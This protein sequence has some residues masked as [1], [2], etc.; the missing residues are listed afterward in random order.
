MQRTRRNI[1]YLSIK[2]IL[3]LLKINILYLLKKMGLNISNYPLPY[4]LTIEPTNFCNLKCP[5]C[6]SGTGKLNRPKG[7]MNNDLFE[8]IINENKNYLINIILHF[9][10]EPLLNN[11]IYDFINYAHNKGIYTMF[12]TNAQLLELNMNNIIKSGLDKLVISLDGL[13]PSTYNKYRKGADIEKVFASLELL[14]NIKQ[15]KPIVELQFLV[16]KHN[17]HEISMLNDIK[18]RYKIDR[19]A[20]KTAHVTNNQDLIPDNPKYSRYIVNGKEFEIKSK[21]KNSC[22]RIFT[23]AVITWDGN[24]VPCCFDKD[25]KYTF[26]NIREKTLAEIWNSDTYK[27]F[28]DKVFTNRKS[29]DI[30][31]NCTENLKKCIRYI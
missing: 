24:I 10:G 7:Y 13:T 17:E 18:K 11:M 16:F 28:K 12:S 25:A 29:I 5:E 15:P 27:I 1:K 6:P 20:I 22:K 8:K 2:K 23:T 4:S 14:K 9:Q 26:G 19:I 3:N 31:L 30:C 21:L